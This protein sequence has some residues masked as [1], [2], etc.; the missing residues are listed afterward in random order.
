MDDENQLTPTFSFYVQDIRKFLPQKGQMSRTYI[1]AD[2]IRY[3]QWSA[4][5]KFNLQVVFKYKIQDDT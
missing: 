3:R 5:P 2:A 4:F 1:L